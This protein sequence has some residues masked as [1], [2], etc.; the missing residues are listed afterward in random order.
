MDIV[1]GIELEH[2]PEFKYL[3]LELLGLWYRYR[4]RGMLLRSG[5]GTGRESVCACFEGIEVRQ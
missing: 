1:E 2:V 4:W 5:K 3:R